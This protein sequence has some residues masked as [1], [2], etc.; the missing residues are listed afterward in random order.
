MKRSWF[1]LF[2]K[3]QTPSTS[4]VGVLPETSFNWELFFKIN[5]RSTTVFIR[6]ANSSVPVVEKWA[7][8]WNPRRLAGKD[9][10][11]RSTRFMQF[12]ETLL[13]S[14][15]PTWA[16]LGLSPT[17]S[18]YSFFFYFWVAGWRRRRYEG[19]GLTRKPEQN[20]LEKKKKTRNGYI[21]PESWKF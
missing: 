21:K 11:S 15:W 1:T 3:L 7:Q 2:G 19:L 5:C 8:E 6:L 10:L 16:R 12:K 4:L 14:G 20:D 13:R 17:S 18:L 9:V